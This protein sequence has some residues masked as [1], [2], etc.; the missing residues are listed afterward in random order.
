M[1]EALT[2]R[3]I[4]T[5]ILQSPTSPEAKAYARAGRVMTDPDAIESQALYLLSNLST[6][7]GEQARQAKTAL[8][9]FL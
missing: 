3:A 6:W 7:R 5:L 1:S 2:F 4:C 9:T 8:R